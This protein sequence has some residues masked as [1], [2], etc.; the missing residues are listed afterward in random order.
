MIV[1][2]LISLGLGLA[3]I[4][5]LI[6]ALDRVTVAANGMDF[7]GNAFVLP[8]KEVER[9]RGVQEVDLPR[10]VFRDRPWA[11]PVG[12]SAPAGPRFGRTPLAVG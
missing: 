1:I 3:I 11:P 6:Y 9:P 10:F 8:M 7:V 2:A 12:T 4:L 5:A